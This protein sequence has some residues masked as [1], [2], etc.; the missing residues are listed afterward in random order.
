VAAEEFGDFDYY[1]PQD[2]VAVRLG[3][4]V[5][6]E[7][8]PG[9]ELA[10]EADVSEA[11][12]YRHAVDDDNLITTVELKKTGEHLFELELASFEPETDSP[13][14]I[15]FVFEKEYLSGPKAG[16]RDVVL[17][18]PFRIALATPAVGEIAASPSV[19]R[20]DEQ[21]QLIVTTWAAVAYDEPGVARL[22]L[23]EARPVD[24][25]RF[26]PGSVEQV[27]WTKVL[28]DGAEDDLDDGEQHTYTWTAEDDE[29]GVVVLRAGIEGQP[30]PPTATLVGSAARLRV[31]FTHPA[32]PERVL[33]F[34]EETPVAIVYDDGARVE[35]LSLGAGGLLRLQLDRSKRAFTL[36]FPNPEGAY[37]AHRDGEARSE[38][39]RI[40]ADD[41][42]RRIRA[43]WTPF[44]LPAEWSLQTSDARVDGEEAPW[45]GEAGWFDGLDDPGVAFGSDAAPL[46][47]VI[48]PRW[49]FVRFDYCD[50][51]AEARD[52]RLISVPTG[53][54]D[55]ILPIVP[56][57]WRT[58]AAAEE[59]PDAPDT[60]AFWPLRDPDDLETALALPWFVQHE[61]RRTPDGVQ[62]SPSP[63]PDGATVLAFAFA[64]EHPFVDRCPRTGRRTRVD[65]ANPA[66]REVPSADR[67]RYYDLPARWCS[68]GYHAHLEGGRSGPYESVAAQ[69]TSPDAPLSFSLDDLVLCALDARGAVTPLS[70]RGSRSAGLRFEP[71]WQVTLF[72]HGFRG[73]DP[74]SGATRLPLEGDDQPR[75]P[76]A[77]RALGHN[78]VYNPALL[79]GFSRVSLGRN[80]LADYP[81]W[82]R[83]VVAGGN[84]FDVFDRRVPPAA[85]EAVG[86]RAAVRW[87]DVTRAMVPGPGSDRPA[88]VDAPPGA[89]APFFSLQPDW[90]QRAPLPGQ[91]YDP[92]A[93]R[94][95]GRH[96]MALLRCCGRVGDQERAVNLH[97]LRVAFLFEH[98][99]GA[100]A[101]DAWADRVL[102]GACERWNGQHAGSPTARAQL[103][104]QDPAAR[105]RLQV[106]V[107]WAA[108]SLHR[109]LAAVRIYVRQPALAGAWLDGDARAGE[110]GL[111]EDRPD[112]DGAFAPAHGLGHAAGL[113]DEYNERWAA[114]SLR[115][116][117]WV[118]FLPGDPYEGDRL[119]GAEALMRGGQL[120]R[121]RYLWPSA[122]WVRRIT[123]VPLQVDQEG[124]PAY[125]LPLH[126]DPRR[127]W[128]H[129]PVAAAVAHEPAPN[130]RG[131][132][133]LYLYALGEESFSRSVLEG[134]PYD[135]LLVVAVRVACAGMPRRRRGSDLPAGAVAPREWWTDQQRWRYFEYLQDH[136]A[137]ELNDR[138][139]AS[140]QVTLGGVEHTF[141]RCALRFELRFLDLEV[142]HTR[143]GVEA[144]RTARAQVE[145]LLDR[146]GAQFE[147]TFEAVDGGDPRR[148]AS[149]EEGPSTGARARADR[150]LRL[151]YASRADLEGAVE[152]CFPA[153][154]GLAGST[155]DLAASD[156]LPLAQQVL[157]D[158]QVGEP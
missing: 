114:A 66:Q 154:L 72:H 115:S 33:P 140:G 21:S 132:C 41:V 91:A 60:R 34:P 145:A 59:R 99:L 127:T 128:L 25:E 123:G 24:P 67:L 117:S 64:T 118:W 55:P 103:V 22:D 101:K 152:D 51:L 29:A 121:S 56:A 89:T 153:M 54:T 3:Y 148:G 83:L 146:F 96:D 144:K 11:R 122:E 8:D 129:W 155:R 63:K 143:P 74:G 50:R 28:A 42:G 82:T 90:E 57:G 48:D 46:E 7:T 17:P 58:A 105:E 49:Q 108:Q 95:V 65:L 27:Q 78:G 88:R 142:E 157:H 76:A 93:D 75:S 133:D 151:R 149:W 141:A 134:G 116:L 136:L 94:G 19:L 156:L 68:R 111:L 45:D 1:F 158:A 2:G 52:Q 102:T 125:K 139:W 87:V 26:P 100:A 120:P 37:V 130:G 44:L 16:T 107:V 9:E 31:G 86:A 97:L 47:V 38:V 131:S 5:E 150:R 113:P 85:G 73:S 81:H 119:R 84:L 71:A 69:P 43:G 147:L 112:E 124:F 98:D 70:P 15:Q 30:E 23:G 10:P 20:V 138:F 137:T 12:V 77:A 110:L 62:R 92:A 14:L 109:A 80:Y 4:L 135:G 35:G 79:Q 13:L 106:E 61:A 18:D 126:D 36:A 40:E 104:P 39:E 32:D 53:I 6:F